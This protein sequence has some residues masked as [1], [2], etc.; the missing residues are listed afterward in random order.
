MI[1]GK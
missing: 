1:E